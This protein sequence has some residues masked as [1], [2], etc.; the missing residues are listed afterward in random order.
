MWR[1]GGGVFSTW[2]GFDLYSVQGNI[3][4]IF[5]LLFVDAGRIELLHAENRVLRNRLSQTSSKYSHLVP[6]SSHKPSNSHTPDN[7]KVL[8]REDENGDVLTPSSLDNE[9]RNVAKD[10]QEEKNIEKQQNCLQRGYSVTDSE[11]NEMYEISSDS[12]DNLSAELLEERTTFGDNSNLNENISNVTKLLKNVVDLN[13]T[14]NF[15][16]VKTLNIANR[17]RSTDTLS[18]QS[19]ATDDALAFLDDSED[20]L[21]DIEDIVEY[22]RIKRPT[23]KGAEQRELDLD[24]TGIDSDSTGTENEPEKDTNKR[25]KKESKNKAKSLFEMLENE[26][27]NLSRALLLAESGYLEDKITGER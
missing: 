25:E 1:G 11:E 9:I 2:R 14:L 7:S 10:I 27:G 26:D 15:S 13:D 23:L 16:E 5:V 12:T 6:R 24:L 21:S 19:K 22:N 4:N 18:K 17:N 8:N 3:I 20:N